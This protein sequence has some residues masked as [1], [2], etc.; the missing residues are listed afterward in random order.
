[1]VLICMQEYHKPCQVA[2]VQSEAIYLG[3]GVGSPTSSIA[4]DKAETI[5][6]LGPI[7]GGPC[8]YGLGATATL[9][10]A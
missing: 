2:L 1:M 4:C 6:L 8:H 7:G 3:I 10:V 5:G 9:S